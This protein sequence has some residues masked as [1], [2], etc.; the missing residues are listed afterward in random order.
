MDI[1]DSFEQNKTPPSH[2]EFTI[3]ENYSNSKNSKQVKEEAFLAM[4]Q[5]EGWCT[6][7]KASILIDLIFKVKA[8]TI[9]EIG[10]WGGKSLIPMAYA[11]KALGQGT[12]IGIDPWSNIE[13]AKG[14]T[15]AHEE[16]WVSIDHAMIYQGLVQKISQFQLENNILLLKCT[17]KA[18]PTIK[19]IDVLHI[20][21]NHSDATSFFDVKK[22][23]PLVKTGG[24][25]IFDDMTW[26]TTTR[27]VQWLDAHCIK[28]AEYHEDNVWGIWIKS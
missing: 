5:L 1:I 10:V 8:Q 6:P 16:W 27:A 19:N 18:A 13:S 22:W 26:G 3:Y 4:E 28:L 15:G 25:I 12:A 17:S 14:M 23:V 11:L 7:F 20:D 9:V 2:Y 21:G 24:F